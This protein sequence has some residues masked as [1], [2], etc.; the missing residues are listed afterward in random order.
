MAHEHSLRYTENVCIKLNHF[1]RRYC[2]E[3]MNWSRKVN[4]FV[5]TQRSQCA[6]LEKSTDWTFYAN[7]MCLKLI[8]DFFACVNFFTKCQTDEAMNQLNFL[9][10]RIHCHTRTQM[11]WKMLQKIERSDDT[12]SIVWFSSNSIEKVFPI[13]LTRCDF[14][15]FDCLC[16]G[17]SGS[18]KCKYNNFEMWSPWMTNVR[19]FWFCNS[20]SGGK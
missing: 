12:K 3:W 16:D 13:T 2:V 11:Q 17:A 5:C 20:S 18:W 6:A 1:I 4:N 14:L 8:E 9:S 10:E 7:D 15:V 19:I